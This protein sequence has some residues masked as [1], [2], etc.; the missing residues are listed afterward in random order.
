[1][2]KYEFTD[3]VH[4]SNPKLKRI[5]A[6]IDIPDTAVEAGRLGGWIE[7]EENLSHD[8]S[9]WVYGNASVYDNARVYG[10]ASV[11][12]SASVSGNAGVY[13]NAKIE[14]KKDYMTFSGLGS[15]GR[16]CTLFRTTEGHMLRVGCWSGTVDE[17]EKRVIAVYGDESDYL[18]ILPALR[19]KLKQW[20]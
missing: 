19:T 18:S 2:K 17:F 4:P 13:G 8:G 14:S 5:R 3:E 12:D 11:Y 15:E 9:C 10:N 16:F 6:L 1:M 20:T 7:G